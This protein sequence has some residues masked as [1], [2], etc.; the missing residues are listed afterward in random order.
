MG[1][2]ADPVVAAAVIF[3]P[4]TEIKG[5]KL[6][7]YDDAGNRHELPDSLPGIRTF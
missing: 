3:P 1:P 6:Y 5:S 2:L 4:D 7:W